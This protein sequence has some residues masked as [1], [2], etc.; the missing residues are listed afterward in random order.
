MMCD[1]VSGVISFYAICDVVECYAI[2][3]E[4]CGVR[5]DV[6]ECCVL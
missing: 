3:G 2:F 1:V 5:C 4:W 6:F